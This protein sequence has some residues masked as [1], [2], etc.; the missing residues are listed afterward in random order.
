MDSSRRRSSM[1]LCRSN[2]IPSGSLRP[3]TRTF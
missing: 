2:P 3:E 1:A